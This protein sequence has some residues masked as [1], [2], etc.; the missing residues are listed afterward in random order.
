MRYTG[1]K[2]IKKALAGHKNRKPPWRAPAPKTAY[3]IIVIGR[4]GQGLAM[5]HVLASVYGERNV[6][7]I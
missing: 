3:G 1:F 7:V 4:D 6:P 5:A 2:I